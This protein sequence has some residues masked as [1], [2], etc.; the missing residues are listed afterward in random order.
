MVSLLLRLFL[1]FRLSL[2]P[3]ATTAWPHIAFSF[4]PGKGIPPLTSVSLKEGN[5]KKP[6]IEGIPAG[7]YFF[8]LKRT[9]AGRCSYPAGHGRNISGLQNCRQANIRSLR[10]L[11]QRL[12][13]LPSPGF[14]CQYKGDIFRGDP[15]KHKSCHSISE[16]GPGIYFDAHQVSCRLVNKKP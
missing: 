14:S 8:T 10:V 2:Y 9:S 3:T 13:P 1:I 12:V 5:P 16:P 4:G 6:N 7:R 11:H 15:A